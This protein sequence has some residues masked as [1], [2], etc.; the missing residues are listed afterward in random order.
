PSVGS[1]VFLEHAPADSDITALELDKTSAK[2]TSILYPNADVIEGDALLHDRRDYYD[3][4]IGNPP[5]GVT[6]EFDAGDE[7]WQAVGKRKGLR[8]GKSET[9]FME[10]AIKAVK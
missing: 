2:V 1:G 5:Y 9:A 7:D 8:R 4:V 3:L 6:V 10:L